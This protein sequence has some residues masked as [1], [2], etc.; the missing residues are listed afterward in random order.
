[1]IFY[2]T[3]EA[4]KTVVPTHVPYADVAGIWKGR[5]GAFKPA[6]DAH[7]KPYLDGKGTLDEALSALLKP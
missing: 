3:A 4:M 1:M 2:T 7:W 6:L 5:M